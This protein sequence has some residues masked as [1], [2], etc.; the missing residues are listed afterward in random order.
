MI[1]NEIYNLIGQNIV[2]CIDDNWK[3]AV[4][5]IE[6]YLNTYIEYS[7]HFFDKQGI[8]KNLDMEKFNF[9]ELKKSIYDLLKIMTKGSDKNK[10]NKAVFHVWANNKFEMEFN[11]DQEL[12]DEINNPS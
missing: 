1:V 3:E 2:E 9:I 6:A 7:G 11:W 4:L 5:Y 10:W 12:D 8:K